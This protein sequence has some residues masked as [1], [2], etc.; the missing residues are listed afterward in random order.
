M[1]KIIR[2]YFFALFAFPADV[3]EDLTGQYPY[4]GFKLKRATVF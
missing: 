3:M 4:R 2:P 1:S